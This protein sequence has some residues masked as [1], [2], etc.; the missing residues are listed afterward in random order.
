MAP[1]RLN[2]RWLRPA[3]ATLA[4]AALAL[5]GGCGGGSG[6]PN[7]PYA[8]KPVPPGPLLIIPSSI[9]VYANTPATMTIIGGVAP[10]FVSSG[11]PSILPLGS[12]T[13]TG[14][15]VLLPG[16]VSV[17]IGAH[18]RDRLGGTRPKPPR[19]SSRRHFQ[20]PHHHAGI[21]GVR[22]EYDLFR[23]DRNGGGDG[24]RTRR[25]RDPRS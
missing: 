13:S 24:H 9:T 12:S 23:P 2:V 5:L 4:L 25:R 18:Y 21:G 6:A 7:N 1:N 3:L 16:N 8:P 22:R 17:P 10:Y 19:P 20:H 11:N 15:I 14:T